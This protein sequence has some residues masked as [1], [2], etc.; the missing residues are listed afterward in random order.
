MQHGIE[1]V[2][3][4]ERGQQLEV[5]LK[6]KPI[7]FLSLQ[8]LSG[9]LWTRCDTTIND[10]GVCRTSLVPR[11]QWS[12]SDGSRRLSGTNCKKQIF[13]LN[14]FFRYFFVFEVLGMSLPCGDDVGKPVSSHP[15]KESSWCNFSTSTHAN[16]TGDS[17]LCASASAGLSAQTSILLNPLQ[18]FTY[19]NFWVLL[20]M[21]CQATCA[22][23]QQGGLSLGCTGRMQ[24]DANCCL[25]SPHD[26]STCHHLWYSHHASQSS[27]KAG[28]V[29]WSYRNTW[30]PTWIEN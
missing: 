23:P 30:L 8:L 17:T 11:L 20:G 6:F 28:Y 25:N 2:W 21:S 26:S 9:N 19:L 13:R 1:I 3:V 7:S 24:M 14:D 10:S 4:F 18:H 16:S 29:A 27:Y 12:P 5:L 15:F 22:S